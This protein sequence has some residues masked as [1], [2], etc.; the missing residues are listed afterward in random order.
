MPGYFDIDIELVDEKE[1]ECEKDDRV[2]KGLVEEDFVKEDPDRETHTLRITV[3]SVDGFKGDVE[4]TYSTPGGD[5][6]KEEETL[7]VPEDGSVVDEVIVTVT[8]SALFR[9][10]GKRQSLEDYD[11]E[12]LPA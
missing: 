6:S 3:Y 12:V 5:L 4:M 7:Y 9:A 2:R 1:P 11:T 8:G 10:D